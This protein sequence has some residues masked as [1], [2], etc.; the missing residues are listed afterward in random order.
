MHQQHHNKDRYIAE[1][2]QRLDRMTKAVDALGKAIK[3]MSDP[4]ADTG[5]EK[6]TSPVNKPTNEINS[7]PPNTT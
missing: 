6:P 7:T 5:A 1:L 3:T 2:E 4:C